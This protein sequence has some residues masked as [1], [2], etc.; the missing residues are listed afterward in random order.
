MGGHRGDHG[1]WFVAPVLGEAERAGE[2][3]RD[4]PTKNAPSKVPT[5]PVDATSA[6]SR[7]TWTRLA[8]LPGQGASEPRERSPVGLPIE[9]AR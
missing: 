8:R 5:P 7:H 4:D 9:R 6:P 3:D 1:L 2:Q